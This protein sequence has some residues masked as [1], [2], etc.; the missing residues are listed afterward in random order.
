LLVSPGRAPPSTSA[1]RT[2]FRSVSAVIPDFAAI[3]LIAAHRER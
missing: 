1:R 2:H 3:E